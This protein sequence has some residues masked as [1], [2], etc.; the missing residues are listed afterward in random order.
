MTSRPGLLGWVAIGVAVAVADGV[1]IHRGH[2]TMSDLFAKHR[3]WAGPVCLF[4]AW[5]LLSHEGR[6]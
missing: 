1:A 3:A 5:H 4:V 6:A 2:R